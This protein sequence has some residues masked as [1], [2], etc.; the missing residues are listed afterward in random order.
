MSLSP[1]YIVGPTASGKSALA[2]ALARG[3]GGEIVNADAFQL[4]RGLDICTAKP[5]PAELALVPH[6]LYGIIPLQ[7]TCDAQ[8]FVD[9]AQPVIADI[10][11]RGKT[12]IIVGGSGLYVKALT[13]G[14]DPLPKSESLREKFE[15][16][17]LAERIAWLAH[18]DPASAQSIN[19]QNERY[20]NRALEISLLTGKPA[21]ELRRAWASRAIH[22]RGVRLVWNRDELN[23]RIDARVHA[24]IAQGL[25]GEITEATLLS[26]TAEKAIGV[27]EIRQHLAGEL[28]LDA[29]VAA[30][31]LA[32][33]Q[34]ARRQD[35]WFRR[36][37]AFVPLMMTSASSQEDNVALITQSYSDLVK[38]EPV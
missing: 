34:Y 30:I 32:T 28:S 4:Y 10:I 15:A 11:S 9:L 29:A 18:R 22:A 1:F 38:P 37:S 14:L 31:Q 17:T 2:I 19:L 13:H 5:S 6:H 35:K 12:P 21:S 24:M 20:V 27:R 33:R 7:E 3:I 36:E 26:D 16:L 23:A 8:R 25:I